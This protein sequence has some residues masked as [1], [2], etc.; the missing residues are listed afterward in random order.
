M[1]DLHVIIPTNTSKHPDAQMKVLEVLFSDEVQEIM[2]SKT[3]RVSALKDP[4][5]QEIFAKDYPGVEGKNIASI[6]KSSPAP[7]P[8]YSIHYGSANSILQAEFE[9]YVRGEKD[10]NTALREAK[11]QIEQYIASVK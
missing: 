2:A 11:E 5:F 10:V 7:A 3:A 1:Y 9:K 6:F 8:G 4:K